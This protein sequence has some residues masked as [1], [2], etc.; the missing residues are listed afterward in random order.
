MPPVVSNLRR[1][2]KKEPVKA[3]PPFKQ[4]HYLNSLRPQSLVDLL[5]FSEQR[6]FMDLSPE[7]EGK[8][9]LFISYPPSKLLSEKLIALR[10]SQV[11]H[12]Q[13]EPSP[14]SEA[15]HLYVAKGNLKPLSVR[16]QSF[17]LV[18]LPVATQYKKDFLPHFSS[19]SSALVNGGRVILSIIHPVLE[20]L[21]TTQNPASTSRAQTSLKNYFIALKESQLYLEGI[22]EGIIDKEMSPF[23]KEASSE[24]DYFEEFKGMPVVLFLKV[25]KFVKQS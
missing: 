25:V 23:F 16:P 7:P 10:P 8:K 15:P 21:L 14:V 22:T 13:V 9:I 2:F 1:L 12:Y 5:Q 11:L 18:Y 19:I 4:F 3:I 24:I 17:D 20:I 6:H